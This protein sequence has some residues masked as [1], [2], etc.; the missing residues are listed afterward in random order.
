MPCKVLAEQ[1]LLKCEFPSSSPKVRKLRKR[2]DPSFQPEGTCSSVLSGL[3][4]ALAPVTLSMSGLH[5]CRNL[6]SLFL[7]VLLLAKPQTQ[8]STLLVGALGPQSAWL[9]CWSPAWPLCRLWAPVPGPEFSFG[10]LTL[11]IGH[12]PY[13][14]DAKIT[15]ATGS[16][17]WWP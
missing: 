16:A 9:L 11:W 17:C 2:K 14:E 15:G 3:G 10:H 5:P 8:P 12:G 13:E 4:A 7:R 1:T 6:M